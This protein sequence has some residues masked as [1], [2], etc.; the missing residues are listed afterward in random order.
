MDIVDSLIRVQQQIAMFEKQFNRRENSIR[1]LAVTKD[2]SIVDIEKI[3]LAGQTVFG[4]NYVKEA[5]AK[6]KVLNQKYRHLEWHYLGKLQKNKIKDIAKY[7]DWVQTLD[8][9]EAARKLNTACE[10][11]NKIMQ[12]CIQVNVSEEPQKGGVSLSE[13]RRLSAYIVNVC[14]FLQLRGSM[15][16]ALATH[17]T[18]LLKKM[19]NEM[20]KNY[21]NLE[22]D[23][24]GVDTLS[25]GM[26]N[27]MAVAIECGSTMV[28]VGT[29][30]FGEK[31]V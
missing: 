9:E 21:D 14:P 27:D 29:A 13:V 25:M 10:K 23:Y 20:K 31:R 6:I 5:I 18:L 22:V 12:V 3:I 26:S 11:L 19:F 4:E 1:L 17:N 28:R 15:T 8:N 7:F 2:K 30:I 16:I 24:V